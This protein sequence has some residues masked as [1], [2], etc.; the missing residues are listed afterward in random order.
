MDGTLFMLALASLGVTFYTHL[1]LG[2]YVHGEWQTLGLR[3]FLALLGIGVGIM[4]VEMIAPPAPV[5]PFLV[6][7]GLVHLPPAL[8]LMLKRMRG[9]GRS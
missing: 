2:D 1:R 6:G 7:F 3:L 8:V 5:L 4:A 9:E